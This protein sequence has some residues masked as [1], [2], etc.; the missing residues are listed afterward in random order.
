MIGIVYSCDGCGLKDAVV[1]LPYR[2]SEED[3]VTWLQTK[4]GAAVGQDHARRSP[5]CRSETCDLRIPMPPGTQW[6]GGPVQQ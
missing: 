4:V 2:E 1:E 6:V 5:K 3:V